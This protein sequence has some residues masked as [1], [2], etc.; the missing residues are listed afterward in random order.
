[1][2]TWNMNIL[3][4]LECKHL[5]KTYKKHKHVVDDVLFTLPTGS[6]VNS[7]CTDIF[8]LPDSFEIYVNGSLVFSKIEMGYFPDFDNVSM[9]L[10]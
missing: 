7:W 2:L 9:I 8:F 4:P 10:L 1:M 6:G 5:L 3:Q